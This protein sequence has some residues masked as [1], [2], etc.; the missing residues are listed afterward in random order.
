MENVREADKW[1]AEIAARLA[2]SYC[3]KYL[4]EFIRNHSGLSYLGRSLGRFSRNDYVIIWEVKKVLEEI[5]EIKLFKDE[6]S[7][8]QI[9]CDVQLCLH[10]LGR[11]H[12]MKL[13]SDELIQAGYIKEIKDG[14]A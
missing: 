6:F 3:T 12:T 5:E 10:D 4:T 2:C 8:S 13:L 11:F 14:K 1:R 9:I 7:F